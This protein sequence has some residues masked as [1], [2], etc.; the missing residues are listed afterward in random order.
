MDPFLIAVVLYLVA[1]ALAFI[2]IFIPSGGM[3]IIL[4]AVA[5]FAS[6]LFGF[7]SS[8]TAGMGMLTTVAATVPIFAY[9]AIQIWPHTPIGKRMILHP[10]NQPGE[11]SQ[12]DPSPLHEL[13]G[14]VLLIE[15]ALM[16]SGQVKVGHRRLNAVMENGIAEAGQKVKVIDIRE[17]N[18]IVRLSNEP[19]SELRSVNVAVDVSLRQ[20]NL[21]DL[22]ADELGLDSIE[23]S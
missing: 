3:L 14:K 6:I 19:L 1:L 9:L 11:S 20:E 21:L 12:E 15:S 18:L 8:T 17:R 7:Q 22:P 13:L 10:P 5:A 23:D 4:A 2:D 16:P